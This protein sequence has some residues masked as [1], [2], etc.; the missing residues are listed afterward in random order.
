MARLIQEKHILWLLFAGLFFPVA[1]HLLPILP[2]FLIGI[3]LAATA[4]PAVK[5]LH[6][7]TGLPRGVAIAVGVTGVFVLSAT[8]LILLSSVLLR[9]LGHLSKWLPELTDAVGQGTA[10]LQEWLLSMAER[11]PGNIRTVMVQIIASF[12]DGGSALLQTT[13]RKL[14]QMAGNAIGKLSHGFIGAVTAIL[15]AFMFS[16]R[17]PKLHQK[18]RGKIPIAIQA[19][20]K[21]FRKSLGHWLLAQGKLAGIAFLLLWLG[22]MMLNISQPLLWAALV[23]MV[24][25]LPILGVGTVLIPWSFVSYLQ[26]NGPRALGLLGIFLLILLVRSVLEPKLVGKELGLDPL[27]TLLCIYAGFRLW[28]VIGMLIAPVAAVCLVQLGRQYLLHAD[29]FKA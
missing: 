24:D 2:P 3:A 19:A 22:F 20:G 11:M 5:W 1:R 27:V 4:E 15:S 28:G 7:K 26:G 12:F 16:M 18:F 21:D 25:I 8:L 13:A 17:L 9:Q 10:L 14:T 6:Q 23:T 29:N